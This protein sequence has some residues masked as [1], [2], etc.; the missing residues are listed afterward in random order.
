MYPV[1]ICCKIPIFLS[2][3]Q[4]YV[5]LSMT[6]YHTFYL[7]HDMTTK[8]PSSAH[9]SSVCLLKLVCFFLN[10]VVRF[11]NLGSEGYTLMKS[12]YSW[13]SRAFT[14]IDTS[15]SLMKG[16]QHEHTDVSRTVVCTRAEYTSAASTLQT[17]L[18]LRIRV[19]GLALYTLED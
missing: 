8:F 17:L 18:C 7:Q 9:T 4:S 16:K 11:L 5:S 13:N 2:F 19:K 1:T 12:E 15:P 6:N 10:P 3:I 14:I